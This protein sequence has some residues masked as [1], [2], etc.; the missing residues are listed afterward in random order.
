MLPSLPYCVTVAFALYRDGE[1]A[2]SEIFPCI[3]LIAF[4][5]CSIALRIAK[6]SSLIIVGA[7]SAKVRVPAT[8]TVRPKYGISI[9]EMVDSGICAALQRNGTCASATPLIGFVIWTWKRE[10]LAP[11]CFK[12]PANSFTLNAICSLL[13]H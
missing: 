11:P 8:F 9:A 12:A 5:H 10:G 3:E 6:S 1:E 4:D 13:F 7:H 2:T